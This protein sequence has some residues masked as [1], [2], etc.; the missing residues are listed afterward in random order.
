[1][2]T[3][4]FTMIFMTAILSLTMVS[5]ASLISVGS[6]TGVPTSVAHDAGSYT[7]TFEVTNTGVDATAVSFSADMTLGTATGT[8]SAPTTNVAAGATETITG[9]VTFPANQADTLT[10]EGKIIALGNDNTDNTQT[11]GPTSI[12]TSSSL[13]L[14][15]ATLSED[16]TQATL[17]LTNDG[18]TPLS[19]IALTYTDLTGATIT[20]NPLSIPTLA[21]GGSETIT[22]DITKTSKLNVGTSTITVT[23]TSG[24]TIT[25]GTVS[26][27][28]NFCEAG[29]Q[30]TDLE[31]SDVNIDN[32]DGDD[33]EW[34]P[35][36]KIEVEVEVSNDADEKIKDVFVEIGLF[37]S[38]GKNIIKDMEDLDDE[39]IDLGSIKDGDEKTA[40]FTFTVPADFEDDKY[41]LVVK[42]YSDDNEFGED[43][44]CTSRVS[45]FD[46]DFF[47]EIDG[48]RETDEEKHIVLNNIK[49]TPSPAQCNERVQVTAEVF[50]IGDE[51]YE[52]QV[53][54]TMFNSELGINDE[55]IIREDFDQGDSELIDFEFDVPASATEKIHI[56]EFKTYYDYDEDVDTYDETSDEEFTVSLRVEGNCDA[57]SN[58]DSSVQIT[59]ELDAETPEAVAGEQVIINA[60]LKNNGNEEATYAIGVDG[61][62][63]WSQVSSI[64]PRLLTLSPGQSGEVGIVL[65]INSDVSEDQELTIRSSHNGLTTEQKVVLAVQSTG[66][67]GSSDLGPFVGHIKNNWF[68]Y[69][70]ILVNVI[71]IIAIILVIRSM[72]APARPT[73]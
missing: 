50:N 12:L 2:N 61:N 7:F 48:E 68:I 1:M 22:V 9:T 49:I 38:S 55:N 34:S 57:S 70:I 36:D 30:G 39:E 37:D 47:Q 72:V 24:S 62:S 71:L 42:A 8:F 44:L 25:T 32:N 45:E 17:T 19:S 64:E 5:A 41:R 46:D 26:I 53:R 18:N 27:E 73:L 59:A 13:S 63:E 58:G 29:E 66:S 65:L 52:D 67:Q 14:T 33:E 31:I 51:D 60:I 10:L 16:Q 28:N 40:T 69:L 3:K 35:L 54:V 20:I 6:L 11:F 56:I 15:S 23:A 21:A 4:L 43:K